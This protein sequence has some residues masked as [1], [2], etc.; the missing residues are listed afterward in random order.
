MEKYVINPS[1]IR[2]IY[3]EEY[4]HQIL[5]HSSNNKLDQIVNLRRPEKL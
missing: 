2:D 1:G 5:L 3:E 4:C